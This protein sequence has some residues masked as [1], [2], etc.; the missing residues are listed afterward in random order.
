M[1]NRA[2][3]QTFVDNGLEIVVRPKPIASPGNVVIRLTVRA[4]N[5]IDSLIIRENWLR[6]L[7]D[8]HHYH[9]VIGS[10]GFGHITEVVLIRDLFS[11][12]NSTILCLGCG[13]WCNQYSFARFSISGYRN[14]RQWL[15]S[16]KK[17]RLMT[18]VWGKLCGFIHYNVRYAAFIVAYS[19]Q[20]LQF[21]TDVW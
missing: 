21:D 6:N 15:L 8:E 12:L 19:T 5:P 7:A 1:S 11:L 3:V 13:I 2:V 9:P 20:K 14:K 18:L 10:E 17:S 16:P 4:V